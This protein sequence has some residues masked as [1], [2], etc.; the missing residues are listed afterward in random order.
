MSGST[1]KAAHHHAVVV[2]SLGHA[3]DKYPKPAN[4]TFSYGT[5]GFRTLASRLPSVVFRVALLAVL[6][7]KRMEGAS[8]GVMI[9]ASHNP[10]Q[11]NGVKVVDPSGEMLDQSWESHATA[12]ANCPTTD[13]LLSTFTTLA[14]HLRVDL[15]APASI[16]Y[17]CD[18]R[19]SSKELVTALETGLHAFEDVKTLDLG[20][21]TT[22]V[23]HYVVKAKN[24]RSGE[25]GDPTIDGYLKKL[26]NAFRTVIGNRGPLSPVY[27]D[28]ANGVGVKTLTAIS[29]LIG[30]L[31]PIKP[32]ND[33]LSTPGAL[34]S[35]C[36]ADYVKTRQA[37]PPSVASAGFLSKPDTRACSFD[38]D[39]DRIVYYYLRDGRDFRLLDGDKIA[40]MVAMFL[41]DLVKKSKLDRGDEEEGLSVGVVQTA[42]ANGSSTKYLKSRNIPVTCVPTG[43]KYLHH[44]AQ[45]YPI[46][47]YFEANGHG[48]V[49]FSPD[50]ITL[51][52]NAQPSSP[53]ESTAIKQLLAFSELINQAVGD[54]LSDMLLVEAVLAHRGWGAA[55][56]D[57]GYEDLP[58]K[59]MKLEVPDRTIFLT[60]DAERKL[61][62]PE[63]LQH[64]IDECVRKV[65]M[66]RSFVRPSGTEDCVRIYAEAKSSADTEALAGNVAELVRRASGMT[67]G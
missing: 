66:G 29:E 56:W 10:E 21:T 16:V 12:L 48:T 57:A 23:L 9:T 28:C 5:A 18:T 54:A 64:L 37:L 52:K 61:R 26:A 14:S 33:S 60:E 41:G 24:D 31:L 55:E 40:V 27:V 1:A 51:L 34:N 11:D 13:S 47:V 20:V 30:D 3:A 4:L 7:S 59:L 63:G 65:D 2:S 46:G 45:K 44:A 32:I 42:Y 39:A 43:V 8:I 38:G 58:N 25:Y 35:Q 19:P 53:A 62:E 15:S 50:A 22:P 49:L 17:A 67:S 36:G 6:R